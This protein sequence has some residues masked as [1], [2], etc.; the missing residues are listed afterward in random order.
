MILHF[1]FHIFHVLMEVFFF[2]SNLIFH[3]L[4]VNRH[5]LVKL[6]QIINNLAELGVRSDL[7]NDIPHLLL[8]LF[9]FHLVLFNHFLELHMSSLQEGE[10]SLELLDGHVVVSVLFENVH[11]GSVS[12]HHF[13]E[14][15]KPGHDLGESSHAE[16]RLSRAVMG[17][18]GH[19]VFVVHHSHSVHGHELEVESDHLP[20]HPHEHFGVCFEVDSDVEFFKFFHG[21]GVSV[22]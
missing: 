6:F 13:S 5:F 11:Q 4:E 8:S 1:V 19:G 7:L 17:E 16:E 9:S 21:H 10:F 18:S 22:G 2:F 3:V 15:N 20:S 14:S 12:D